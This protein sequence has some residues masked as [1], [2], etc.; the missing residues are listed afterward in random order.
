MK[1]QYLGQPSRWQPSKSTE[2]EEFEVQI[3]LRGPVDIHQF[4]HLRQQAFG[5]TSVVI[6]KI[7]I[8]Q[9]EAFNVNAPIINSGLQ[10]ARDNDSLLTFEINQ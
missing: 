6:S 1:R 8:M 10:Y 4:M 3:S 9:C 5:A 7:P 2:L